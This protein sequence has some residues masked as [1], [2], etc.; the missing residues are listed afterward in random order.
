VTEADEIVMRAVRR[1]VS[2]AGLHEM[3]TYTPTMENM[4]RTRMRQVAE[5]LQYALMN[6]SEYEALTA[7]VES[8]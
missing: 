4:V 8:Q 6:L 1:L 3:W 2:R 5:Y 7:P